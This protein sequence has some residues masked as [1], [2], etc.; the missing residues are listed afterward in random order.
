MKYIPGT[1]IGVEVDEETLI[2]IKDDNRI[3]IDFDETNA[4]AFSLVGLCSG[5]S[6]GE[7]F[8]GPQAWFEAL[9]ER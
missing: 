2:L 9:E 1:D 4:L 3:R 7:G 5:Y 8:R 6:L